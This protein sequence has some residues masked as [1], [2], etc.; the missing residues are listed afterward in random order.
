MTTVELVTA[1]AAVIAAVGGLSAG[2]A[3]VIGA[4]HAWRGKK[5]AEETKELV[6]T[7]IVNQLMQRQEVNMHIR[8]DVVTIGHA[9][10]ATR[11][12]DFTESVELPA[13]TPGEGQVD[14]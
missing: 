10:P 13:A 9:M 6:K 11:E 4:V 12:L 1:V 14:Q 5:T 8:G 2:V 7:V 3:A